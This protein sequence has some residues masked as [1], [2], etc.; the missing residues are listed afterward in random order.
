V[1]VRIKLPDLSPQDISLLQAGLS[2]VVSVRV[3]D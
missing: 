2:A 1:P 3:R